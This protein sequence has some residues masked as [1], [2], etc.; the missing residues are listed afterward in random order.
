MAS[1]IKLILSE[2]ALE[3]EFKLP[4]P[5]PVDVYPSE[6]VSFVLVVMTV[7]VVV[8]NFGMDVAVKTG[9]QPTAFILLPK[10]SL[11]MENAQL[12]TH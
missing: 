5:P 7:F 6:A 4:P 8:S 2:G 10:A 12:A 11:F 1:F 9:V 3:F